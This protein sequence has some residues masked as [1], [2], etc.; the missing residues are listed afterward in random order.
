LNSPDVKTPAGTLR[1]IVLAGVF[2]WAVRADYPPTNARAKK[3]TLA[4]RSAR[5]RM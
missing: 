1:E 3:I 2:C 5:R 4:G